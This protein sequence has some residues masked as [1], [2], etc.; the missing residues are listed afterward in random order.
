MDIS[1]VTST[2]SAYGTTFTQK[3]SKPVDESTSDRSV[4]ADT[5]HISD[6]ARAMAEKVRD[7][8]L[9]QTT[10]EVTTDWMNPVSE[11]DLPVEACAMPS[12]YADYYPES[13]M[14]NVEI[15]RDFW[16][17]AGKL[18]QDKSLS[19]EER[20][21]RIGNYLDNDTKHQKWLAKEEFLANHREEIHEYIGA[22]DKYFQASLK[23]N[24]IKSPREY[25][26]KVILNENGSE[27]VHQSFLKRIESD[28][29]VFQLMDALG[30]KV[31][32]T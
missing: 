4:G 6:E 9:G 17:F 23:E 8:A 18:E 2:Q 32:N 20:R 28:P 30:I 16:E 27:Q 26:E 3:N 13:V 15:D 11:S 12:W 29:R 1:V 7:G 14:A 21:E 22:L 25:Y 5:V 19:Q 10:N 24:G 31:P